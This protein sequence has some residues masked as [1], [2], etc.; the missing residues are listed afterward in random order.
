M[1]YNCYLFYIERNFTHALAQKLCCTAKGFHLNQT[2]EQ[3]YNSL[4]T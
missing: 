1:I 2:S 3:T 4:D